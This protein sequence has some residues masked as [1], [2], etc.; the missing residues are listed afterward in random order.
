MV[1]TLGAGSQ[2]QS[3]RDAARPPLTLGPFEEHSRILAQPSCA[4]REEFY[5]LALSRFVFNTEHA[6]VELPVTAAIS[7]VTVGELRAGV[8]LAGNDEMRD[9]RNARLEAVRASF[10]PLPVDE[11][12][13]E[14]YGRLLALARTENRA[15]NASDV[16]IVATAAATGRTLVTRDERQAALARAGRVPARLA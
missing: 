3:A 1:E 11:P 4:D 14:E 13:A 5:A 16:L 6:R 10:A 12:V 2:R 9:A 8:L 15:E 7:A